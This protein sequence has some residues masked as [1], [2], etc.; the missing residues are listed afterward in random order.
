MHCNSDKGSFSY[1]AAVEFVSCLFVRE[2]RLQRLLMGD[3]NTQWKEGQVRKCNGQE[4]VE[5]SR[6]FKLALL[7][8]VRRNVF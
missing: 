4:T 5:I 7:L 3:S 2:T 1:S 8:L 6:S